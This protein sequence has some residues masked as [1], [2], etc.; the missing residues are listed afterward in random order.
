MIDTIFLAILIFFELLLYVIFIDVIL[1]WLI[2]FGLKF[3]PKFISDIIDPIYNFIKKIIPTTFGPLDLTPI[4]VIIILMFLRGLI[5]TYNPSVI[6]S[7]K[8]FGL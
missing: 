8:S 6:E 1:S 2:L 5:I 3:R 7:L 4:I